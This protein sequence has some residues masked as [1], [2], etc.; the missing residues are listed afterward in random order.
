[1]YTNNAVLFILPLYILVLKVLYVID[2]RCVF[3]FIL[4]SV[5]LLHPDTSLVTE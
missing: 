5:K 4:T 3:S 2:A 1:M